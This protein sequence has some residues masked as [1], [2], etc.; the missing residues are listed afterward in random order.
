M[1][2][3]SIARRSQALREEEGKFVGFSYPFLTVLLYAVKFHFT[4]TFFTV[5]INLLSV[6]SLSGVNL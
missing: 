2:P 6:C 5:L 1:L 3:S 4:F